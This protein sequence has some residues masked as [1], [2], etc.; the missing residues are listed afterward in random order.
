[1]SDELDRL[2]M[3]RVAAGDRSAWRELWDRWHRRVFAF[4]LKRCGSQQAAE[5]AHSEMWLKIWRYR[6][7]YDGRRPFRSWMFRIAVNAGH[8]AARAD[9]EMW[10]LDAEEL[11]RIPAAGGRNEVVLRDLLAR[12]LHELAPVD[13]NILLLTLEGFDSGE[14][15]ELLE[16]NP[17]TVRVRLHRAREQLRGA[18]EEAR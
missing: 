1:M 6:A 17:N 14:I 3:E 18:L 9:H 5:E 12:A 2:A 13:R 11:A 4:L 8:D 16:M 7:S 15:G 10:T